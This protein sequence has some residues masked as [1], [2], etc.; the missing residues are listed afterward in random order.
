MCGEV[1]RAILNSGN[2]P[3]LIVGKLVVSVGEH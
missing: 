3:N 2:A 1:R